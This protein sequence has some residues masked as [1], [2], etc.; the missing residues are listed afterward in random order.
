MGA[1]SVA[2]PAP[3]NSAP[4]SF[5]SLKALKFTTK[6]QEL[7]IRVSALALIYVLAFVV[8]LFSV[9][10]YESMIHEFDPY[11]NYRTT[12]FLTKN[13]F[14]EFWNWFDS[15]SWYPL[16]RIIG[17][18]LYPGL[19]VTAAL[20]H[21]IL[22]FFSFAVHIREVCV[23]TAPFFASNTTLVAYFFGKE[24]WDS[25]AGLVAAAL[26]AICPGYISRSVAGSYDNEG[27]A[28]FALLLT[29]YLFVKAVN[30]GSL[31]WS[32]ASAFG[33]FYMVSAWGGYVFII[34]LVPLYVLVLLVTGRYSMRLYVAYNCMYVVGMLLAMQIRFVGFQHVQSGE[35]MAAMGVFFLLQVFYFLDWVKYIL[36]DI[37]LFHSFLRITLTCAITVGVLALSIG[38]AS[39]YISPWTGRFYSLLDPT[40]AK[41]HIPIIASVS[42]HQPT[43]WSSFMFDFHILLFLFPA[44]L[45]FCFKRLSDATIF[46]VM[47]G[48]TSMYFAGVMVRLI[49]VAAPA[50]CLVSSIAVSA[51][52][53]NLS[54]LVRA[55]SKSPQGSGKP[56]SGSKAAAKASADQS[57][58]FQKNGA[59]ALL[60]GALYL[61]CRYAI[62]C[63]WV[64][65]EAYSSPS[66]VLAARGHGGGRVIFDDYREAYY[67]LR[68]N[69]PPDA[70]VMSWWD[71]GYQITAMGNRTVI[72]DNNTWNNTHI[73][74]VGRAMSSYEH[75]AYEIMLS[76]DVNYVLVVFGGVTGYSSDDINKFLWMVR[77]GGGVFPVIK[78]PDYLVNG[79]FRVD[80]G[81]APKMLNCLM[82]KLCYYRF[83]EMTT[84]YGKPPGY[85][86]VR[87]VEI[88][89]KDIKL[90][91]LEEAFTTSNWIVRIYKV[92]PPKNRW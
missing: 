6:Q 66:I 81:A 67:W 21:R 9:L 4:S 79:E 26:I 31:A 48:L 75:E 59:I 35:H 29:F 37:K 14:S 90:E 78:E 12:L 8:R 58:P 38:T 92:K 46:V 34:N 20:I 73:A 74:T 42:E 71:Y 82:Y 84:E 1:T 41:D 17:G 45:Y 57:L 44:G 28:I 16:G 32:L 83:G 55:K 43:A 87:G 77:I 22:H 24:I 47:Y 27:V 54:S 86:R 68:Q 88:G 62:H 40:Y 18:T 61:L 70:K 69:T 63:T 49:L 80:K 60:L 65:S 10:R 11:F 30:T 3:L 91:Y 76:L 13:G 19:M 52:V 50:M 15:E 36:N 53:K 89:N 25:G 5:P 39:G 64:T 85:D 7:L 2:S 51:T 23:L 33:Y 72:V 56:L